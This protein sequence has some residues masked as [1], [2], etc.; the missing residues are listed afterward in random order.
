MNTM[1]KKEAIRAAEE[2]IEDALNELEWQHDM[3]A[4]SVRI[5]SGRGEDF[6]VLI[7]EDAKGGSR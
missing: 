1:T 7:T 3:R 2:Q 5:I 6:E 4:Y